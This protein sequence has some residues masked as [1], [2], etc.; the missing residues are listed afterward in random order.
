MKLQ[1]Y[2]EIYHPTA[3]TDMVALWYR[4]VIWAFTEHGL[5]LF[6]S[7]ILALRPLTKYVSQGWASLS[8]SLSLYGGGSTK[9]SS[10]TRGTQSSLSKASKPSD[11]ASESGAELHAIGVRND[12]SVYREYNVAD[13]LKHPVYSAEAY[14]ES[15]ES[16]KKL[17]E[18]ERSGPSKAVDDFV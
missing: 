4:A 14:N 9:N 10:S 12:V 3:E 1:V 7:S 6:A 2:V 15:S 17:I 11:A 5:S 16:Q 13:H 18:G 8:S